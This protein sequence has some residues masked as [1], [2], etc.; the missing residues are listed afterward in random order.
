MFSLS[1]FVPRRRVLFLGCAT[2]TCGIRGGYQQAGLFVGLRQLLG[3]R[4]AV[5]PGFAFECLRPPKE[6]V[7]CPLR[8][9]WGPWKNE[10]GFRSDACV[11]ATYVVQ[12]EGYEDSVVYD[13]KKFGLGKKSKVDVAS[14][15]ME[16]S[17]RD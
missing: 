9:A 13:R 11:L 8:G 12:D 5:H 10:H 6:V 3:R 1:S 17:N 7:S 14:I 4:L 2:S 15:T 16:C